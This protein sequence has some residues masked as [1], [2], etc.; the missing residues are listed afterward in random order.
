MAKT[1]RE[2]QEV[3]DIRAVRDLD[4][5]YYAIAE[6]RAGYGQAFWFSKHRFE[7]TEDAMRSPDLY[8]PRGPSC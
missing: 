1:L 6:P 7:T 2:L 5:M 8:G 3:F 4:G